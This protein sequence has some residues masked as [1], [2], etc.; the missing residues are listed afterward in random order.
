MR[1]MSWPS[2]T[3]SACATFTTACIVAVPAVFVIVTPRLMPPPRYSGQ[4]PA[5]AASLE[6]GAL[7]F[8]SGCVPLAAV[9]KMVP[10]LVSATPPRTSGQQS[11]WLGAKCSSPSAAKAPTPQGDFTPKEVWF[12]AS[13]SPGPHFMMPQPEPVTRV[14]PTLLPVKA[15]NTPDGLR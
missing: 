3:G 10:P 1:C 4:S 9:S 12:T 6:A 13:S 2:G 7:P 8:T 15:S 11:H 5:L 14:S